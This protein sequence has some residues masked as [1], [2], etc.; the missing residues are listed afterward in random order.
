[1]W[2][3]SGARSP[4]TDSNSCSTVLCVFFSSSFFFT[5]LQ[6]TSE[7]VEQSE[8]DETQGRIFQRGG[9]LS[10]CVGGLKWMYGQTPDE[11][12]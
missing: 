8:M 1:M 4:R 11:T 9:R 5:L 10:A 12:D 7:F 2:G 3:Q 6:I